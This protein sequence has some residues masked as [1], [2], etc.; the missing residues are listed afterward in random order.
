M[1]AALLTPVLIAAA[2]LALA[3]IVVSLAKGFA[4]VSHLRRQLA[5]AGHSRM[6]TVRHERTV[7]ARP[8]ATVRAARR[9]SR[10]VPALAPQA[11]RRVAA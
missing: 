7:R 2:L 4:A 6:V 11:R 8:V 3:T 1:L 10:P 5:A 9:P